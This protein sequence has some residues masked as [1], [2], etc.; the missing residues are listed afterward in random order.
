[1]KKITLTGIA[2]LAAM[3]AASV[4]AQT[5]IK[6]TGAGATFPD[7]IYKKWF[8]EFK[9]ARNIEI[10]YQA[11]GSGAGIK[12]LTEGTVDFGAS[13]MPMLDEQIAAV[14]VHPLHFPTVLGGIVLI[15]NITGVDT[16]LVLTPDA[17]SGI[18]LGE[19]KKW[20]D[21]KI[22]SANPKVKLP[23]EEIFVVR[24]AESSGTTFVFTDYLSKVNPTW[25]SKVGAN[26]S[27]AWP[28]G[29]GQAKND[30]VAGTVK[31]T[32]NSIGYVE[33]TYAATNH[34]PFADMKNA[35]G[36]VVKASFNSVTEAAA[37]SKDLAPDFRGSITNSA[38]KGA[39]PISS[40]TWLLIPSQIP[41][42]AKKKAVVDF[43]NWMLTTGQKDAQPLS[44]APLPKNIVSLEQRQ[45]AQIK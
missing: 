33:L 10:N 42:P 27:V 7:P 29:V 5:V 2:A 31:Q 43:L 39:W 17:V 15:Y 20:N 40:Y 35:A 16:G 18:Y 1:M 45:I 24:R 34:L 19:I 36:N 44:Y 25:K 21:P 37:S 13:D 6:L 23:A 30:G 3:C 8:G 41:D 32:P 28:V 11:L 14:K 12:Q 22:A 26:A 4:T 38:G 9:A